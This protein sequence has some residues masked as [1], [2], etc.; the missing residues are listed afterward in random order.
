MHSAQTHCNGSSS[1][2]RR[3]KLLWLRK[4]KSLRRA[5]CGSGERDGF[6]DGHLHF[7]VLCVG[8]P[9]RLRAKVERQESQ[10]NVDILHGP[11]AA[12]PVENVGTCYL[13]QGLT[14]NRA[15]STYAAIHKKLYL[16]IRENE[17]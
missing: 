15:R 3:S 4:G 10:R 1:D 9:T 17:F 14:G 11:D 16:H 8:S 13:P 12:V 7:H 5:N 2:S 6:D